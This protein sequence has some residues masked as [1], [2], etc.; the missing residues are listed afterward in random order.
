MF[1]V[2]ATCFSGQNLPFNQYQ[3]NCRCINPKK[4]KSFTFRFPTLQIATKDY[5]CSFY[6]FFFWIYLSVSYAIILFYFTNVINVKGGWYDR[7]LFFNHNRITDRMKSPEIYLSLEKHM[8]Y[9]Y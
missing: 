9:F 7:C 6:I 5:F 4:G 3:N 1:G 2:E 8:G